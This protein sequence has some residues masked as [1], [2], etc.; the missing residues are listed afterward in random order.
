MFFYKF[1]LILG[2][3]KERDTLEKDSEC[4]DIATPQVHA[5][6]EWSHVVNLMR[7][8]IKDHAELHS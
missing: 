5:R 7:V 4:Q 8:Q 6:E 1:T 3:K 2:K